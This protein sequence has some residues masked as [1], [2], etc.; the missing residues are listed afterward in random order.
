MKGDADPGAAS[1]T[2]RILATLVLVACWLWMARAHIEDVDIAH[3]ELHVLVLENR[4]P[5]PY[6]YKLWIV[7]QV[8]EGVRR[9]TGTP[10]KNVFFGNTVASLG[11]LLLAHH[12][13]L[14][15]IAPRG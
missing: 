11:F 13:W 8:L 15:G 6:Q 12:L 4:A 2:D 3:A 1:T 5:D 14:K 7:T 10:L 9:L